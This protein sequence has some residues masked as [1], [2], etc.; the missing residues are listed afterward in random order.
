MAE[1]PAAVETPSAPPAGQ[2][3]L[4]AAIAEMG[5]AIAT[6]QQAQDQTPAAADVTSTTTATATTEQPAETT[7]PEPSGDTD[8]DEDLD[9]PEAAKPTSRMG[10]LRA[11]LT[12]AETKAR[13]L[14]QQL[15]Q[16]DQS[17]RDALG[18]FI[19]LV[20]PD[21]QFEQLRQKAESGDWEAKQQL[22]VARQWRRMAAPIADL[23]HRATKQ[24][25]DAAL[26]ELRTLDGMDGDSH[27]KLLSAATP[28]E[29]LRLMHQLAF[30]AAD[31]QHKE[32]IA[33]LESEIQALKTNRA[34]NG[35][36]PAN[37]GSPTNG[38]AG[39]A[40]LIDP[41]TGL[42]T[43]EAERL[44]WSEVNRRFGLAS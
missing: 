41:K 6:A 8:I 40:G 13:T 11:Q 24:Q 12:D 43:D 35:S 25:F 10:R 30:K 34:A 28:G 3:G 9:S 21:Q 38:V 32:R 37:G 33:S 23:A 20:L 18:Q 16:R 7:A 5:Q 39:L 36:Q 17:H 29:Q 26:A 44:P 14:Q 4:D 42:L 2:D 1:A 27:Q 31:A 22:D 19:D 15:E